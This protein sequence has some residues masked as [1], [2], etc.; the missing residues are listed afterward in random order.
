MEVPHEANP[1]APDWSTLDFEVNC[2]RC[3]YNLAMLA[4]PRCPECGLQFAWPVVV[5]AS[6]EARRDSP[7][8][9]YR[10]RAKPVRSFLFTVL[11][12]LMP[13][14][15]W[16]RTELTHT[17][18][19]V[20]LGGWACLLLTFLS[21]LEWVRE[22]V[23]LKIIETANPGGTGFGFSWPFGPFSSL[24]VSP[25]GLS[26]EFAARLLLLPLIVTFISVYRFTFV[27]YRIAWRH[28]LRIGVYSWAAYASWTLITNL[29]FATIC[30]GYLH[31]Q[32]LFPMGSVVVAGGVSPDFN[33]VDDLLNWI[34]PIATAWSLW[35][36]FAAYLQVNRAWAGVVC[37]MV[38]ITVAYFVFCV[39]V[40]VQI[41]RNV[42]G[43]WIEMLDQWMPGL[44]SLAQSGI[45][46]LVSQV[47]S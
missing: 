15:L 41:E 38:M 32:D 29:L 18:R 42:F 22:A 33:W 12:C 6:R 16:R 9:E 20:A 37:S 43:G 27:R 44:H 30:L 2:P 14:W 35:L 21:G 34:P 8:F 3:G 36:D 28:L 17:P 45:R 25:P 1:N 47:T 26:T 39:T 23:M 10:W 11:L 19:A 40:A 5:A 46:V 24:R 31:S 7:L 4:Q 13:G